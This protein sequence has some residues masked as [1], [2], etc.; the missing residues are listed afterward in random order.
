MVRSFLLVPVSLVVGALISGC[1]RE[2]TFDLT[3]RNGTTDVLYLAAGEGSGVIVDVEAQVGDGWV[4]VAPSLGLLCAPRCG[5]AGAVEC[6]EPVADLP[7]VHALRPVQGVMRHLAGEWW[8]LDEDAGCVRPAPMQAD[9]RAWICWD[10]E[11]LDATTGEPLPEPR[12][13]GVLG[14]VGGAELPEPVCAALPFDL[15]QARAKSLVFPNEAVP[16]R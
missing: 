16:A 9:L 6:V 14:R 4:P 15:R 13:S 10:N 8:Y 5:S 11:A 12:Y 3:F 7:V 2:V 1:A